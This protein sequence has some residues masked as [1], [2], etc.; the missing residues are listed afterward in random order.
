MKKILTVAITLFVLAGILVGCATTTTPPTTAEQISVR[1]I[2]TRDFGAEFIFDR[3]AEVV[4]GITAEKALGQVAELGKAGSYVEGIDGLYGTSTEYWFYYLNGVMA[5]VFASGYKLQPG[6]MQHWDYHDYNY[7]MQ[8]CNA[9]IGDFPEPFLHGYGGKVSPTVVAYTGNLEGEAERLKSRLGELGV[10]EVSVRS[11]I[12]LPTGDKGL[13]NLI[14]MCTMDFELVA[15]LNE[16]YDRVGLFAHFKDGKLQ[17]FNSKGEVSAEYG[18]GCGVIQAAQN[19]WN[20]KGS[21]NCETVVWMVSGTD[22]AGVK[23]AVEALLDRYSEIQY[24]SAV[25]IAD[26][27]I[28]KIPQ[29]DN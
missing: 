3:T 25:V 24:A 23:S 7:T 17:A 28:I 4:A 22:E 9:I 8:G 29:P 11:A 19:I 18:A 15:E 20:P 26:G 16:V 1:V 12:E 6:D 10:K 13:S 27:E 2:A 21:W 14:L 5:N